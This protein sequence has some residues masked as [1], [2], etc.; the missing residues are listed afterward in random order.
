M[1]FAVVLEGMTFVSFVVML[2]SGIQKRTSGWKIVAMF[3]A[4]VG[5]VQ[6]VAMALIVR[7]PVSLEKMDA[8]CTRRIFMK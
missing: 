3:L 4:L 1:S 7:L 6:C 2:S 8:N 5:A